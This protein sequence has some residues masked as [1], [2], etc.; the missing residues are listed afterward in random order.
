MLHRRR[1]IRNKSPTKVNSRNLTDARRQTEHLFDRW[2]DD[3]FDI[4]EWRLEF[5]WLICCVDG[6][7]THTHNICY[8]LC[9]DQWST[10]DRDTELRFT[11]N[12]HRLFEIFSFFLSVLFS[13]LTR[14]PI[15]N[16]IQIHATDNEQTTHSLNSALQRSEIVSFE[17]NS[18]KKTKIICSFWV[19]IV[20]QQTNTHA[21]QQRY[22]RHQYT[23][24]DT[25]WGHWRSMRCVNV[26]VWIGVIESYISAFAAW[27]NSGFIRNLSFV[28]NTSDNLPCISH[29][30]NCIC[31]DRIV[32][33]CSVSSFL[34]EIVDKQ[35]IYIEPNRHRQ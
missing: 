22:K 35:W 6:S 19:E 13:V 34:R 23:D 26:L 12:A 15:G 31:F 1:T 2:P 18:T 33:Y 28:Q 5:V 20:R 24:T 29:N 17:W 7:H 21:A 14:C 4:D 8:L 30:L 10:W 3:T 9:S 27:I 11:H 25:V 16:S 32:S